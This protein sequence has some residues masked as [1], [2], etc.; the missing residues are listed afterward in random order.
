MP[1]RDHHTALKS[2]PVTKVTTG[3]IEIVIAKLQWSKDE[4]AFTLHVNPSSFSCS[5][6][7]TTD[8]LSYLGFQRNDRCQFTNS[9]RCY[10]KEVPEGL[11][12]QAFA[13]A[14]NGGFGQLQQA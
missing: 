9:G 10:S 2:E 13:T 8:W 4:K 1:A 7:Q 14:F 5:G 11:D 3:D 6:F 12:V